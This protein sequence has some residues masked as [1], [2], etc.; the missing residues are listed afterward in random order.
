MGSKPS[1]QIIWIVET[2][3]PTRIYVAPP[4]VT[5]SFSRV[6]L[7]SPV[8]LAASRVRSL[9]RREGEIS[10]VIKRPLARTGMSRQRGENVSHCRVAHFHSSATF[11]FGAMSRRLPSE[12]F[13]V[14]LGFPFELPR[15]KPAHNR[16]WRNIHQFCR[17]PNARLD[18]LRFQGFGD[19]QRTHFLFVNQRPRFVFR[20][21]AS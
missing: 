3:R 17:S 19:P 18:T 8:Y 5:S 15:L 14:S 9:G 13:G 16:T 6:D 4:P 2:T 21:W 12:P 10:E 11:F 20:E 1:I 7:A